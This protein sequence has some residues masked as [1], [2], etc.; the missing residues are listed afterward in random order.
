MIDRL[1]YRRDVL[2]RLTAELVYGGHPWT[3]RKQRRWGWRSRACPWCGEGRSTPGRFTADPESLGYH[4]HQCGAS[5]DALKWLAG[6]NPVTAGT[7]RKAEQL[8]GVAGWSPSGPEAP[9]PATDLPGRRERRAPA[10]Q[11]EDRRVAMARRLWRTSLPVPADSLHPARRW[12]SATGAKPGIWPAGQGWPA[13]M[14]WLPVQ[15][16]QRRQEHAGAG[17]LVAAFVPLANWQRQDWQAHLTAVQL[18]G[19]A[20]TGA[21]CPL[22]GRDNKRTYGLLA[23]AACLVRGSQGRGRKLGVAEG[24]ADAMAL[25]TLEKRHCIALGGT[26]GFRNPQIQEV[27]ARV[28]HG[29]RICGDSDEAGA[30][31]ANALAL[32]VRQQGG[33][34]EHWA[35]RE[36]VKD[37]ADAA[38]PA[39][40]EERNP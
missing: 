4:C 37:A 24:L 10:G 33:R 13:A 25:A 16:W 6:G 7:M 31:A 11:A 2:P 3:E 28:R 26:P 34:A 40:G 27:L 39:R 17:S 12:A 23:G 19:I 18:V 1:D 35:P 36:G 38:K 5:G 15:A 29:I 22:A 30:A 8:A 14:R 21:Q 20:A 9:S 32:A